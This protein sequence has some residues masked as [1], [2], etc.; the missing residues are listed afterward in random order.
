LS[1]KVGPIFKTIFFHSVTL[2]SPFRHHP[3]I[4]CPQLL[5]VV[6]LSRE[7]RW[8][9]PSL[10][11]ECVHMSSLVFQ[12]DFPPL[13]LPLK[14]HPP[15]QGGD[16]HS[17]LK[18]IR[19]RRRGIRHNTRGYG[20]SQSAFGYCTGGTRVGMLFHAYVCFLQHD[21][22]SPQYR[23]SFCV[24]SARRK[25]RAAAV[26]SV[27]A[28]SWENMWHYIPHILFTLPQWGHTH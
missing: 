17:G 28:D 10:F 26:G 1:G 11:S 23:T 13:F 5:V 2:M 22:F 3:L 24:W 25:S 7:S 9:N 27:V 8:W 19:H 21:G 12:G 4:L 14:R 6:S 15:V 18:G 16:G 20:R